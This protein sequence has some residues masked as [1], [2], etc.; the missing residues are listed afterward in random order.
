MKT[1]SRAKKAV[2]AG[3]IALA[4]VSVSTAAYAMLSEPD[5]NPI[6]KALNSTFNPAK[7]MAAQLAEEASDTYISPSRIAVTEDGKF[8]FVNDETS[9]KVYKLDLSSNQKVTEISLD[10]Q[11]NNVAVNGSDVYVMYGELGG[12][13]AKYSLDL[14]LQGEPV[15]TGHTPNAAYVNGDNL[16]VANRFSNTVSVINKTNMQVTKTINVSR[17]PIAVAA[18]GSKLFVACHLQDGVA[19]KGTVASKVSVIDMSSQTKTADIQLING[20]EGVKDI[21]VSPDGKYAYV[22]HILARYGYSTT[23]LDRGWIN[24][25]AVTIIDTATNKMV[26]TV[27][28]DQV[29]LGAG[30]PWGIAATDDKLIVSIS[31]TQEAIVIDRQAMHKKIQD[32]E[33][34]K[35]VVKT[36]ESPSQIPDYLNFLDG[37]R[38]RV[39]LKG[40]NPRGMAVANNKA[41]F[42]QYISGDVAVLDLSSNETS[43]ISL[44]TQLEED[45]VRHGEMLW[46]DATYCYQSW[47]SCASC[48]PDARMDS[49]NWD[50]LN[51]G[52]GNPKSAKSMLYSHRTPPTMV[53]GIRASAEI[54]V[55]AGMQY[56]QF[57]TISEE[58]QI[59]I[60]EYLKSL[61]P[62]Q[63]PYLE[64]DGTLT[65][66]AEA[67]KA[68][69]EDNCASCHSGPFF[70][71]LKKHDPTHDYEGWEN[72]GDKVT[73]YDTPTL[74]EVWRTGPYGIN[75]SYATIYDYLKEDAHASELNDTEL[76]QLSEYVLS[77]GNEG[78][79]YALE[80]VKMNDHN[81]NI[82]D[83]TANMLVPGNT[84]TSITF[85]RQL[86]TDKD[87]V[88]TFELF[89]AEGESIKKASCEISKDQSLR[90]AVSIDME[91]YVIPAD[92]EEGSYFTVTIVNKDDAEENL[93]TPFVSTYK[94]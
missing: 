40:Q 35:Q 25:N 47:E 61:Q 67:G 48:H 10:G 8:A 17:E 27:L 39:A 38:T 49:V 52:L 90:E 44:G 84:I 15:V 23:Q 69:F 21:C 13:V 7:T 30:N 26:N 86:E 2:V 75:G 14:E 74:V 36:L 50:N 54:A 46:N 64:N 83:D 20:A 37:V 62:V 56:I 42:A 45:V 6:A 16:F 33:G 3:V 12:K 59:A 88:A 77:I 60:D 65:A 53:T 51:D 28:L 58:D 85:R 82:S 68:L 81:D 87:A 92:L 32:V 5:S 18:S 1:D 24:T 80:Q 66:D 41:Y 29:E 55:R 34:G 71:D 91:N 76:R 4:V 93:A 31:G 19:N 89:D 11:V 94:G 78:E 22:T 72:A 73:Q 57:N 63:S 70:T 9:K 43:V 79:V